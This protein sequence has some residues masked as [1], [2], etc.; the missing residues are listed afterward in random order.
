MSIIPS[1]APDT[2][3]SLKDI[4]IHFSGVEKGKETWNLFIAS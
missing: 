3:Q 1:F 2:Y 4:F